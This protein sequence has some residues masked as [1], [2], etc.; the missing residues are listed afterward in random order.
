MYH[1]G[2][3]Y[4]LFTYFDSS[5]VTTGDQRGKTYTI[6]FWVKADPWVSGNNICGTYDSHFEFPLDTNIGQNQPFTI[7]EQWQ[8]QTFTATFPNTGTSNDYGRWMMTGIPAS[9][10]KLYMWGFQLEENNGPTEYQKT[11]G[12]ISSESQFGFWANKGGFGGSIQSPRIAM[13]DQG[14]VV[15]S[16]Q[17]TGIVWQGL[18]A[19]SIGYDKDTNIWGIIG[20]NLG[21]TVFQ[22]GSTNKIAGWTINSD[23]ITKDNVS[24]KATSSMRGLL[25]SD[26]REIVKIGQFTHGTIPG[27]FT[28]IN[29]KALGYA[30]IDINDSLWQTEGYVYDSKGGTHIPTLDIRYSGSLGKNIVM[31]NEYGYQ[32]ASSWDYSLKHSIDPHLI[33]GRHIKLEYKLRFSAQ[34]Y[35]QD[36]GT[37]IQYV[38]F[39]NAS[40]DVIYYEAMYQTTIPWNTGSY[41]TV[42]KTGLGS[43]TRDFPYYADCT[44]VELGFAFSGGGQ[45]GTYNPQAMELDVITITGYDGY[46][47]YISQDGFEVYNGPTTYLKFANDRYEIGASDLKLNGLNVPRFHGRLSSAPQYGVN[48]GDFYVNS[49][50]NYLYVCY[51]LNNLG[52]PS[53]RNL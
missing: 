48:V 10:Q 14:I 41:I 15:R 31:V 16:S 19:I 23:N 27:N 51:Y 39:K 25:V 18:N 33:T 30:D 53:W 11:D 8:R 43:L 1:N 36:G 2:G 45:G 47:T 40:G 37:L 17:S 50:N 26:T 9:S 28:N 3:G 4:A 29:T 7:T 12:F 38:K 35:N 22:L 6:S 21:G 44:T 34:D 20:R 46:T 52:V 24:L 32:N 13:I 49:S 42:D 5:R